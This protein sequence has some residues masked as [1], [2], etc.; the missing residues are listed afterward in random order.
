MIIIRTITKK[1]TQKYIVK[2]TWELKCL[3]NIYWHNKEHKNRGHIENKQEMADVNPTSLIITLNV[4]ALSS[5]IESHMGCQITPT[6][7]TE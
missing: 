6:K 7:L 3:Y 4:N 2:E 5:P 1:I